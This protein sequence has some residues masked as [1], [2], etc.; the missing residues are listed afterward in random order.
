MFDFG[1][2]GEDKTK[3]SSYEIIQ[4]FI[5]SFIGKNQVTCTL[6]NYITLNSMKQTKG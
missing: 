3:A 1:K 5:K 6:I 4:N 2:R